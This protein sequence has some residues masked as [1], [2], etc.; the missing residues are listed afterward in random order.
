MTVK[1]DRDR[2]IAI[3]RWKWSEAGWTECADSVVVEEPL[4]IRVNG[5]AV[6]VTMRTPGHDEDLAAGFLFTEGLL[7]NPHHIQLLEPCRQGESARTGNVLNVFLTPQI[8]WDPAKVRRNFYV[9][10]SC[11][12]CGKSSVDEVNHRFEPVT[13]DIRVPIE[14]LLSLPQKLLKEQESFSRTGSLHAA[15]LADKDG[16]L[17]VTRED[18]GRHNAV[19]KVIGHFWRQGE[20][21][22]KDRILFV[23]GRTSFEIVQKAVAAG[24][25]VV[26]SVS[27]PSSLSVDLAQQSGIT[28]AGFVRERSLNLYSHPERVLSSRPA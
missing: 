21:P 19:D 28:L 11:G 10:S 23:S 4:E 27:G 16:R 14:I 7:E 1:P 8:V 20:T 5:N 22:L 15:A 13:S 6:S 26:A 9:S 2:D 17:L 3:T 24:I 12:V 18:V 25:P